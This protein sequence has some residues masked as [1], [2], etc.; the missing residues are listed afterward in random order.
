MAFHKF[1]FPAPL[2]PT[3][4]ENAL[5]FSEKFFVNKKQNEDKTVTHTQYLEKTLQRCELL[6]IIIVNL[7]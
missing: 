7:L 5:L 4:T 3:M 1:D 2:L 6:R